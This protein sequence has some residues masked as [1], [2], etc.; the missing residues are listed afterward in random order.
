MSKCV[1]YY[2]NMHWAQLSR[3]VTHA[4][5]DNDVLSF[6][7]SQ[8]ILDRA[9]HRPADIVEHRHKL[10]DALHIVIEHKD[11]GKSV[12]MI[13]ITPETVDAD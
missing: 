11:D 5:S 12:P 7:A 4:K 8:D 2:S 6:K 3:Y 13:D 1:I 9:G 10:E